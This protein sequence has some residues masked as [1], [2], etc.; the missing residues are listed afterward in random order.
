MNALAD[1]MVQRALAGG[2]QATAHD[3]RYFGVVIQLLADAQALGDTWVFFDTQGKCLQEALQRQAGEMDTQELFLAVVAGVDVR[4]L[5]SKFLMDFC[6]VVLDEGKL[7][8]QVQN[9][10]DKLYDL[11]RVIYDYG[12][13]GLAGLYDTLASSPFV[14]HQEAG[15]P[16]PLVLSVQ[17][18]QGFGVWLHRFFVAEQSI[19]HSLDALRGRLDTAVQ[20][21]ADDGLNDGQKQA[22]MGALQQRFCVITGGPGTGKTFC[23]AKIV[24]AFLQDPNFRLALAAP[25][26]K[27]AL[28]MQESL[29]AA[30]GD[31]PLP[32]AMTLHR[33]LGMGHSPIYHEDNPLPYDMIVVDE[34]SMLGAEL[35]AMLCRAVDKHTRLVWLGDSHQLSAVEAGA[36]LFEICAHAHFAECHYQ[37]NVS[38]RFDANS[39]IGRLAQLVNEGANSQ[40]ILAVIEASPDSLSLQDTQDF[41]RL[42]EDFLGFFEHCQAIKN[43]KIEQ[44]VLQG[45]FEALKGF[46]VLTDTHEGKTGDIALNA[47]LSRRYCEQYKQRLGEWFFGRVVMMTQ[48]RYDL[49]LYNGDIGVC[50][51]HEGRQAVYFEGRAIPVMPAMLPKTCITT[52]YAMT[53]HKSQGSEF[54]K[55]AIF[56]NKI[57]SRKLLYTAITRAKHRIDLFVLPSLLGKAAQELTQR[58]SGIRYIVPL[59]D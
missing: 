36:V 44:M 11:L 19:V 54:D 35:A 57:A 22:V 14:M 24:Q 42:F 49:G 33:L 26:G 39:A 15:S 8:E 30:L 40:E 21:V 29:Q 28:R 58:S 17:S 1:Y 7:N 3:R 47:W 56:M 9:Q 10:K 31:V 2:M 51:W 23:V 32:E 34:A 12:Q 25:T 55:V 53:V 27:A 4:D 13:K 43:Q 50:L 52:A 16:K 59:Q 6:K 20:T 46:R 38:R 5:V 48:N 18:E 45:V 41:E 37:L